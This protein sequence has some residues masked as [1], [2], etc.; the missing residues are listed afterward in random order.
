MTPRLPAIGRLPFLALGLVAL[1]G[2][3]APAMGAPDYPT[4]PVKIVVTSSAGS[5][6]DAL[7]R[8]LAPAA[9]RVLGQP[10]VVENAPGSGGVIGTERVVHSAPDGYTL[11]LISNNHAI[12]PH[13]FRNLPF[14][15]EKDIRPIGVLGSTPVVLVVNPSVPATT[16]R[17][18]I[19]LAQRRPGTL[20]Y[21]SAG[22][23]TVLHLAAVLFA[24]EAGIDL[25]HVPYK[26]LGQMTTDLIG[27]QIDM[28]FG[29]VATMAAQIRAGRLRPIA[30][31]TAGRSGVLP[32]VPTFAESGLPDYRFE[33]WLALV[34]PAALPDDVVD[35]L[36]KAF[37][38]AIARPDVRDALAAQ[39]ILPGDG[40]PQ[41]ARRFIQAEMVKHA[42]L[43][44]RSGATLD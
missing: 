33:G 39:G 37:A 17:E 14:D 6:G 16:T 32:E 40:S 26:S 34:G 42:T 13:I 27:G 3:A 20:T 10:L 25:R 2:A 11:G 15:S 35:R 18:L 21:G 41:D 36:G 38:V 28:G 12:N 44:K 43:V 30:V 29:G 7:I 19:A 9:E 5:T 31:S 4:R 1:L 23:G 8:I 22:N 24:A